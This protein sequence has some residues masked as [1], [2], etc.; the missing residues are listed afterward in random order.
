MTTADPLHDTIWYERLNRVQ[1]CSV[2]PTGHF[3]VGQHDWAD[4]GLQEE[5]QPGWYCKRCG[6]LWA[7]TKKMLIQW[8]TAIAEGAT[9]T[10]TG[11]P[12]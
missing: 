8:E 9:V 7:P 3:Q 4:A 12:L 5:R 6:M 11:E 2:A 1:P 10:A